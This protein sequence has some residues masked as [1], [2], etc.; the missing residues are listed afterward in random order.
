MTGKTWALRRRDPQRALM[1]I[2]RLTNSQRQSLLG[3]PESG[4]GY[5]WVEYET[6]MTGIREGL[7]LNANLLVP[8][9]SVSL[10]TEGRLALGAQF[11]SQQLQEKPEWRHLRVVGAPRRTNRIRMAL[12]VKEEASQ[13]TGPAPASEADPE[14]C[15]AEECFVRF[16][17]FANDHRI[18]QDGQLLPGSYATTLSDGK[19]ARTGAEAV[20]RYAL[21]NE[22][23]AVFCFDIRPM[24]PTQIQ[25]GIAQPANGQPGGGV[26]VIFCRGTDPG[27]VKLPP[28]TIPER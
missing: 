27:A 14:L 5:Q 20:R 6:P 19:N 21:P 28:R 10:V 7:A 13:Q 26:E 11:E 12:S 3:Q 16:S 18:T 25:R 23:P 8:A 15:P 22:Q 4:M 9:E 24:K 17:A 2:I 1:K